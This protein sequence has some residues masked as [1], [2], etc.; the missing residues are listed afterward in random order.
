[1]WS[2]TG[3]V[4]RLVPYLFKNEVKVN[5]KRCRA[6][7]NDFFELEVEDIDGLWFHQFDATCHTTNKTIILWEETLGELLI[8]CRGPVA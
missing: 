7:I 3:R 6:M 8:S 4:H 5:W 2:G 1:M